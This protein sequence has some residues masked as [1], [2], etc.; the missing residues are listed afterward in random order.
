MVIRNSFKDRFTALLLGQIETRKELD[1]LPSILSTMHRQPNA[2]E[3]SRPFLDQAFKRRHRIQ[4]LAAENRALIAITPLWNCR[5]LVVLERLRENLALHG[6]ANEDVSGEIL[7]RFPGHG[8]TVARPRGVEACATPLN[9][10]VGLRK[11]CLGGWELAAGKWMDGGCIRG[12]AVVDNG[13]WIRES[14]VQGAARLYGAGPVV[15]QTIDGGF[16]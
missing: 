4:H 14:E 7:A 3:A 11:C 9:E 12:E 5:T 10:C 8:M 2:R 6:A 15:G 1:R 13:D 16:W